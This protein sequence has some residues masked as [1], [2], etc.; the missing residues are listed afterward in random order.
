MSIL[1]ASRS[2]ALNIKTAVFSLLFTTFILSSVYPL[3][4]FAESTQAE[5]HAA[6][7]I[8]QQVKALNAQGKFKDAF[9]LL[10]S[11]PMNQSTLSAMISTQANTD[12]DDAEDVA[13]KAVKVFPNS[14]ELHYLRGVIMGNQAQSSIFSALSYAEK[15]LQSFIKATELEPTTIKYRKALMSFYLAAPSIAGGDEDLALIQL[16]AIRKADELEGAS[17]QVSFYLM[18]D[19]PEKGI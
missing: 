16:N 19:K 13:N 2:R 3:P 5:K 6:S 9:A 12:M 18:T 14:A 10:K 4:L 7:P 15:S 8:L 1:H 11:A 17:S